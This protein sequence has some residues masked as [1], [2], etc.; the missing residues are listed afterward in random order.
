MFL[1]HTPIFFILWK[2]IYIYL[3]VNSDL[4][5]LLTKYIDGFCNQK[6]CFLLFFFLMIE[7][8]KAVSAGQA[9]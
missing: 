9:S 2:D 5:Y 6:K 3:T 8:H 4:T 7:V 1:I